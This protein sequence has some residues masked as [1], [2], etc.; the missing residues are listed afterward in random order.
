MKCGRA[1]RKNPD[2]SRRKC[3]VPPILYISSENFVRKIFV[4]ERYPLERICTVTSPSKTPKKSNGTQ[5]ASAQKPV[6]YS[7]SWVVG[8]PGHPI[9]HCHGVFTDLRRLIHSMWVLGFRCRE[10]C[11]CRILSNCSCW[12]PDFLP[13]MLRSTAAMTCS[14]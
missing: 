6:L 1:R 4:C 8:N 13:R 2:V 5:M 7:H 12:L 3:H 10:H 9:G 11:L 14:G